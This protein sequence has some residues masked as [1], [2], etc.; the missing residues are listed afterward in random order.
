MSVGFKAVQWSRDKYVYDGILL[1]AVTLY[2]LA[3]HRHQLSDRAA[4][5]PSG[6]D[7]RAHPCVRHLRLL[8]AHR[9][10][11]DR[12]A[13]AAQSL[14]PQAP[15]QSPPFRRADIFRRACARLVHDRMVRGAGNLAEPAGGT[16]HLAG[17]RQI[18]RLSVQGDRL[19]GAAAAVPAGGHQSRLLAVVSVAAGLEV[20]AHDDLCR[21]RARRAACRARHH[22]IRS[23]SD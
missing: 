13:G 6:G 5:G 16:D 4:E 21:L 2:I 12:A 3:L 18:H 9:H 11:V 22:A 10:P 1:A 15:V 7:R 20:A 23:Q 19:R 8:H 14:V 17:L